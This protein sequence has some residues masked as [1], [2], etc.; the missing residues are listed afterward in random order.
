MKR[1]IVGAIGFILFVSIFLGGFDRVL[2]LLDWSTAEIVGY[3]LFT[4]FSLIGGIL[5]MKYSMKKNTE[6]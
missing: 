2:S 5:M 4:L 6:L 1:Q 3:N